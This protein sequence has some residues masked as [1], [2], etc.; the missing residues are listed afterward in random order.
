M[1][2]YQSYARQLDNAFKAARDEYTAEYEK[3]QAA[4]QEDATAK[5]WR[6]EKYIGE[7]D[8]RRA[9]AKARLA[10]LERDF[11]DASSRIWTSFNQKRAELRAELER[12]IRAGSVADPDAIDPNG[13]ALL[14]SGILTS[15]DFYNLSD[16]Y[17]DN[18]TMLRLIA[19]YAREA[20]ESQNND[21]QSRSAIYHVA[22]MCESG[23]SAALRAWD[24][25]STAAD[26]CSG[27]AS[28]HN[29]HPSFV[30]SMGKKWESISQQ[31]IED[32]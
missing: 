10:A 16:K 27:Q 9:A 8:M 12:D 30:V 17:D 19:K 11:N 26:Y 32:F 24:N 2:K 23:Q 25:L 15:N 4:K 1:S 22:E 18:P 31:A 13:L 21:A 7:N 5:E 3:L 6:A 29:E 20:A 14:Q 28:G